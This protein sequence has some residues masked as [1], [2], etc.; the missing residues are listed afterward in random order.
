MCNGSDL[1]ELVSPSTAN[2][3]RTQG[4]P[5]RY[6]V[7]LQFV[8]FEPELWY[9]TCVLGITE[10]KRERLASSSPRLALNGIISHV[11]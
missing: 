5:R 1:V 10:S 7:L 8:Y 6:S 9:P 3:N 11:L 2:L 4:G